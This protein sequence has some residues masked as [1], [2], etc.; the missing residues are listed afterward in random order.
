MSGVVRAFLGGQAAGLK[1]RNEEKSEEKLRKD[2]TKYRKIRK[3]LE[4]V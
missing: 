4:I 2:K 3:K 1:G